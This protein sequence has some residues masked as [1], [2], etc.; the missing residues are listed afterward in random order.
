[1]ALS[2]VLVT[3]VTSAPITHIDSTDVP[4]PNVIKSHDG[5]LN[6]TLTMAEYN[7]ESQDG[8]VKFR[9]RAYNGQIPGPTLSVNPGGP[10]NN[11]N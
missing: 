9:T 7:F 4:S 2:S 3:L 5:I 11:K 1:M 8:A 10:F 6:V